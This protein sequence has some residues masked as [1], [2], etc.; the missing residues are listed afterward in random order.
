MGLIGRAWD[1]IRGAG[2]AVGDAMADLTSD[3]R[4]VPWPPQEHQARLL[5]YQT[6]RRL[7]HNTTGDGHE[8]VFRDLGFELDTDWPYV[9]VNYLAA[10][11]DLV[12]G[13]ACDEGVQVTV[14]EQLNATKALIDQLTF[15]NDI[16]QKVRRWLTDA[17]VCGDTVLKVRYNADHQRISVDVVDPATFYPVYLGDQLMSADIGEVLTRDKQ[18]HLHIERHWI[19]ALSGGGTESVIAHEL[20]LLHGQPGHGYR[21]RPNVDRLPLTALPELAALSEEPVRTG[22]PGLLLLHVPNGQTLPWGTSDYESLLSIQGELNAAETQ[23][24]RILKMHADPGLYGPASALGPDG[25]LKCSESK[26]WPVPDGWTGGA[27]VGY[28]TWG[29][30]LTAV[31][32]AIKELKEAFVAAAGIDMSALLPQEGGGP[33]SGVALRLSQMRTQTLARRKQQMFDRPLRW[34][35]T[36]AMEL[37]AAVTR[38]GWP[39]WQPVEGQVELVS[40]RDLVLTWQDGLPSNL[41]EDIADQAA[42]VEAGLQPRVDAIAALHGISMEAAQAKLDRI[43][44][45]GATGNPVPTLTPGLSPFSIGF[46]SEPTGILTVENGLTA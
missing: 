29:E 24:A 22:V 15:D 8:Q 17:S 9:S 20:Y 34:L 16:D 30:D 14:A 2:K 25:E 23:R 38:R 6:Y 33:T 26:F 36:T 1:W 3:P 37:H 40:M 18:Y 11:T 35:Y 21:Y 43:N 32:N 46:G 4:S 12:T 44:Q 28:V 45:E 13:R 39:I 42:M 31:E 5:R 27:P 41:T 19:E 7:Y 10:L